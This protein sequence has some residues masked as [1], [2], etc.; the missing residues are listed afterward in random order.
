MYG[1][2]ADLRT[3]RHFDDHRRARFH[4]AASMTGGEQDGFS[5]WASRQRQPPMPSGHGRAIMG[6]LSR[7]SNGKAASWGEAILLRL[8]DCLVLATV[9]FAGQRLSSAEEIVADDLAV[10]RNRPFA[11]IGAQL[12]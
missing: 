3:P 1:P 4:C 8:T 5:A 6:T 10:L 2:G 9:D 11:L 12:L 7:L